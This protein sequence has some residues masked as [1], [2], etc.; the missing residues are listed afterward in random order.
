[1]ADWQYIKAAT[2]RTCHSDRKLSNP[3]AVQSS[4]VDD[5]MSTAESSLIRRFNLD[6]LC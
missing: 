3:A 1:M 6:S 2:Q 5:E 4:F